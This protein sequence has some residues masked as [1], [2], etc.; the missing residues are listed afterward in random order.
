MWD[1][2]QCVLLRDELPGGNLTAVLIQQTPSGGFHLVYR[3]ES[4]VMGIKNLH[5]R[6][7]T[8]DELPRTSLIRLRCWIET[9]GEG[10]ALVYPSDGL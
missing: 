10:Y 5:R 2:T 3:T 4:N 9:R 1:S 7:A 8:P 6:G